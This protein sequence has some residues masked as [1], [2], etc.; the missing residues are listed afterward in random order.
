MKTKFKTVL[1]IFIFK[2]V[3]HL[4]SQNLNQSFILS[5]FSF[6]EMKGNSYFIQELSEHLSWMISHSVF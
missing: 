5:L 3:M 6:M 4:L 2:K 1:Q